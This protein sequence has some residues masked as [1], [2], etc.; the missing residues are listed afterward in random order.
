MRNDPPF[1][2]WD[3]VTLHV[4]GRPDIYLVIKSEHIMS[5]F[6]KLL[7]YKLKTVDGVRGTMDKMID[8]AM[9]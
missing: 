7:I 8:I 5:M 4:S 1:Y 3:C 6:L 2:A 9:Q